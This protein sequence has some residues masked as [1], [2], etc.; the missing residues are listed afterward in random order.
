MIAL[1][2]FFISWARVFSISYH[3]QPIFSSKENV[4]YLYWVV[5]FN[6]PFFSL[7]F[8]SYK[9]PFWL[10]C[11]CFYCHFSLCLCCIC[12]LRLC[13]LIFV[14]FFQS[15]SACSDI[16]T[17]YSAWHS[18]YIHAH[19][20]ASCKKWRLPLILHLLHNLICFGVHDSYII[21]QLTCYI[22][23]NKNSNIWHP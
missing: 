3:F 22:Y 5:P 17:S 7:L 6:Y 19:L 4:S 9:C 10:S 14:N 13:D 23:F 20:W 16:A 21:L 15:I 18:L 12:V 8:W 11:N 2:G 1:W